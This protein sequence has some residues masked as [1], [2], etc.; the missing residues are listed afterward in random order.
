MR[1]Q[2]SQRPCALVWRDLQY[3]FHQWSYVDLDLLYNKV[4]PASEYTYMGERRFF[5][6]YHQR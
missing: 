5:D 4:K 3:I 6:N 1:N 2:K